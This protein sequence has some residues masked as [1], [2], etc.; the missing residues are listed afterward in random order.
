MRLAQDDEI[1]NTLAPTMRSPN[2]DNI[3][4]FDSHDDAL[5]ND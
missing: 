1:V 5:W 3:Q 2:P 4:I